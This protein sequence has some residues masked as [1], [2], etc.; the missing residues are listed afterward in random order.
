MS[1]PSGK[2][3]YEIRY[4]GGSETSH[5]YFNEHDR[6]VGIKGRVPEDLDLAFEWG[7][8]TKGWSC[9]ISPIGEVSGESLPEMNLHLRNASGQRE[10]ALFLASFETEL[11]DEQGVLVALSP[12]YRPPAAFGSQRSGI[13]R[14]FEAQEAFF[15]RYE[16][17][18]RYGRL[19]PGR[20]SLQVRHR[21]PTIE[22][23]LV[24]NTLTFQVN[25][26]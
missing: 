17:Q 3:L 16:L 26:Q 23:M 4:A 13:G 24:S 8:Y 20:Y 2:R 9:G 5:I 14:F 18:T 11:R 15:E 19:P 21:H 7:S 1:S 22:V 25:R 6:V 12:N 10:R